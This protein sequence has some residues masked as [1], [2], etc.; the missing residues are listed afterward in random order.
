M[1]LGKGNLIWRLSYKVGGQKEQPGEVEANL[2]L[3]TQEATPPL[4]LDL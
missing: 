4:S 1:I 2:R 3:V